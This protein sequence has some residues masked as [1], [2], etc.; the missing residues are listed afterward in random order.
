MTR[1]KV[2][3]AAK[4]DTLTKPGAYRDSAGLYLKVG[5]TGGKS[6]VFRY[7]L[8]GAAHNMGLGKYP[9]V[10]LADARRLASE[11]RTSMQRMKPLDPLAERRK[12]K[13]AIKAASEQTVGKAAES[14]FAR[15][16]QDVSAADHLQVKSLVERTCKRIW[17]MPA[18]DIDKAAVVSV[19]TPMFDAGK[20]VTAKR[21]AMYV[22]NI[23]S[24]ATFI[25]S[26]PEGFNPATW[27]GYLDQAFPAPKSRDVKHH[28][29][30]TYAE[31]PAFAAELRQRQGIPA[32]ALEFLMLT[33][34][35]T[36]DVRMMTWAQ[37]DITKRLWTVPKTKSGKALDVHLADRAVEILNAL[38]RKGD[39]VFSGSVAGKPLARKDIG[40][41]MRALRPD[42]VVHGLRATFKTWASARHFRWEAIEMALAHTVGNEVERRYM[43]DGLPMERMQLLNE[44]AQYLQ[45]PPTSADVL[46]IRPRE[47]A[48]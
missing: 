21:L 23:L 42:A 12:E 34:V 17:D 11:Y 32:R 15:R 36:G 18:R 6:W 1:S 43:R 40:K 35:R 38:P 47:A 4:I 5:P 26:R 24:H 44:W 9:E 19:L 16:A 2:L 30:L 48:R 39:Y 14:W 41:V 20:V 45:R 10:S 46:P 25:G 13:A 33:A 7:M 22:A 3:S 28:P 29:A 31:A 27:K 8:A 37:V